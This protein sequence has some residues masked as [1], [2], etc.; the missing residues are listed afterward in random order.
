MI[1]NGAFVEQQ[2][3]EAILELAELISDQTGCSSRILVDYMDFMLAFP[4]QE[5]QQWHQ[6]G[7]FSLAGFIIFLTAGR[8]PEFA[9]YVGKDFSKMKVKDHRDSFMDRAWASVADPTMVPRSLGGVEAGTIVATHTAHVHRAPRPPKVGL[10]RTIF[11]AVET[12]NTA[13][14]LVVITAENYKSRFNIARRKVVQ[15]T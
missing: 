10:R 3:P 13:C 14:D 9:D 11:V 12:P 6:D 1:A 15:K 7:D 8:S 5:Q 4:G 2:D